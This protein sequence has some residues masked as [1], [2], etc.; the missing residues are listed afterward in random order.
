MRASRA[1]LLVVLV[2]AFLTA[3]TTSV[4]S[5]AVASMERKLQH[6]ESNGALS[7]PDPTPTEFTEHEI[8]SYLASGKVKLPVGVRS[9]H[10]EGQP[11][12]VT[13]TSRVDF[14]QLK[15]GR[16]SSN[17]LLSVFT[18]I[19]EVVVVAHAH[20][21]GGQGFVNVDSVALDNV[22]IPRF[23]LQ[24]FV[25]KY[26]QP[27]Y[28]NIGLDSRFT[29]PDRIDVALVGMHKLTVMQK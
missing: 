28:P 26:L 9:V 19:H 18:G 21:S 16:R 3:Q 7:H 12:V 22:D 20:G 23:V 11:G 24:M 25:E 10:L 13:G 15:A 4:D 6:I 5:S 27:K 2:S 8:N 17:P 1:L 14:D 29:L